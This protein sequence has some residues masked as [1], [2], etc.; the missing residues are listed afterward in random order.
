[1]KTKIFVNLIFIFLFSNYLFA[2]TEL[3]RKVDYSSDIKTT[4]QKYDFW[5]VYACLEAL[6]KGN[7]SDNCGWYIQRFIEP[8][9]DKEENPYHTMAWS[10]FE[11]V[12][13]YYKENG[14]Y[15]SVRKEPSYFRKFGVIETTLDAYFYRENIHSISLSE[16]TEELDSGEKHSP[17]IIT[18]YPDEDSFSHMLIHIGY[19]LYNDDWTD[20][21]SMIFVMNPHKGEIEEMTQDEFKSKISRFLYR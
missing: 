21:R 20:S 11:Y 6:D 18:T 7:Q 8:R 4:K 13:N 15:K 19:E 5:C 17:V 2:Q 16:I 3:T 9:Y 14:G 12:M 1:M 10:T